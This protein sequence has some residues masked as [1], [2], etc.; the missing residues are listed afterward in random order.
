[1]VLG[2]SK[3]TIGK[4]ASIMFQDNS[5]MFLQYSYTIL[6]I[7]M[8]LF[9]LLIFGVLRI[10]LIL[11]LVAAIL[12]ISFYFY[13]EK[14]PKN[15]HKQFTF[16]EFKKFI[17]EKM[18]N[19]RPFFL[20]LIFLSS[21]TIIMFYPDKWFA[22]SNIILLFFIVAIVSVSLLL[23]LKARKDEKSLDDYYI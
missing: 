20:G 15:L 3:D 13:L 10:A 11:F 1:M 22:S 9:G 14:R 21:V 2:L 17:S 12:G 5:K 16:K 6:G 23:L 7:F 8:F 18:K 4:T 19:C